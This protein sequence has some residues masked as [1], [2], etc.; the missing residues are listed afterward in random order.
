MNEKILADALEF[1][2]TINPDRPQHWIELE[3]GAAVPA[4]ML[5]WGAYLHSP[6]R[7]RLQVIVPPQGREL[8]TVFLG[9]DHAFRG[10]PMIYE[11]MIFPTVESA[12][13][14]ECWRYATRESAAVG[15]REILTALLSTTD[16]DEQLKRARAL[17]VDP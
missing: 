1:A 12:D 11:T 4:S 16:P 7:F 2:T 3:S 6:R 10:P 8:S 5:D 14:L 17:E 15:H 13:G 9:F